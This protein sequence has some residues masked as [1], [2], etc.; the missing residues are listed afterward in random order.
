MY[1][2]ETFKRESKYALTFLM[3]TDAGFLH[4]LKHFK[5]QMDHW[6]L[7][8]HVQKPAVVVSGIDSGETLTHYQFNVSEGI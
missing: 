6:L 7:D 5:S 2:P 3:M 1:Q 4:Y 8:G